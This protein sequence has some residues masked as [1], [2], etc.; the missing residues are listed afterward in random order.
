MNPHIFQVAVKCQFS[1]Y[2]LNHLSCYHESVSCI[3]MHLLFLPPFL[4]YIFFMDL[5]Q[6]SCVY[7]IKYIV[8]ILYCICQSYFK[9][10][11]PNSVFR[12]I[13]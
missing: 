5:T 13:Q 8:D 3:K 7:P 10:Q 6:V 9:V 12:L 11:S 2:M 4:S 1:I